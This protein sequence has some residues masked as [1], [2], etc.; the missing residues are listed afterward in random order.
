MA[1]V[2]AN[3]AV[4][5]RYM[6]AVVDGDI[7]T[8]AALQHPDVKWWILGFGDMDRATFIASVRDGLIAAESRRAEITGITA[9]GDRVA[10]EAWSE[11]LF[12]GKTY[13]NQYHNLLVIRDGLIVEGRE[14]MDTR[15]AAAAFG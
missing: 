10:V 2:E 7:D 14:Y 15:A 9:E 4:A 6:Q 8:V 3:K 5:R 11:M 13:R 12:P 1:D